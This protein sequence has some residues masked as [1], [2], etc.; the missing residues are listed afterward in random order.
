MSRTGKRGT[1][2]P[3]SCFLG[4]IVLINQAMGHAEQVLRWG[5]T[6]LRVSVRGNDEDP[7]KGVYEAPGC[8]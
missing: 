2:P 5:W 7:A 4:S 6:L 8:P 3:S 1:K